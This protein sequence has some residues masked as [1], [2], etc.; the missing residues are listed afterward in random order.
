MVPEDFFADTYVEARACFLAGAVAAGGTIVS[1]ANSNAKGP[2]GEALIT[3][4]AWFGPRDAE[5]AMVSISGTHGQEFFAGAATQ[6]AWL[7]NGGPQ[8]LPDGIAMCLIH[9]NNAYGAA[10]NSRSNE[11]NVDPNRNFFD[12]ACPRRTESLY[13]ELHDLLFPRHN[14]ETP[15]EDKT[16]TFVAW[17][18]AHSG[19][20]L[21]AAL[22]I[23][24]QSH[25]DGL[26]Y[27]GVRE[28]WT[29][30][31]LKSVAAEFL[32][33]AEKLA[34][35]DWHTGIG[36]YGEASF[37][38]NMEPSSKEYRWACAW[39]DRDP[40]E[41][42][43]RPLPPEEIGYIHAGLATLLR[44]HGAKVAHSVVE[45]GTFDNPSVIG[46]LLIDRWLR[47]EC[48]DPRSEEAVTL[49]TRMMERLNPSLRSW[50]KAVVERSAAIYAD[51]LRGL[52]LW[53]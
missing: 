33:Q 34:I 19:A 29:T 9:A 8:S 16:D 49:R 5:S 42:E 45:W 22:D 6:R 36:G 31:N 4:V 39:W 14:G 44:Q 41:K 3:D 35:I 10:H 25:A 38:H 21:I 27:C 30:R 20:E 37:L 2:S 15:F 28:E 24:Q 18:E 11:H 13:G 32:M 40:G 47:F 1:A 43:Q 50:R 12:H 53:R 48:R 23:G 46:A 26:I 51:T 17:C 52:A 7:A